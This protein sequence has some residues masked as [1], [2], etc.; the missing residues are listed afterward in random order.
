MPPPSSGGVALLQ[1]LNIL[2]GFPLA[3]Y[4]HNS[5][6]TMHL[7]VEAERR[8]YADRSEWLGDPAF[9]SVPVAGLVSKPTP[10]HCAPGSTRRARRRAAAVK[11]GQPQ[12]FESLPDDP[13][14]RRRRRGQR[15]RHDDDAQR[16]V[17]Q[18]PGRDRAPASC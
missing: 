17:R 6:R 14:L 10:T 7:M 11:P 18:R 4:G 8:V 15:R 1:L 3:E 16:R 12:D 5:S 13:L 2:E 9:F